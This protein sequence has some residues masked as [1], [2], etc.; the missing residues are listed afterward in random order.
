MNSQVLL[1][2]TS[3]SLIPVRLVHIVTY[4]R[5]LALLVN[6]C[7]D[8]KVTTICYNYQYY[9]NQLLIKQLLN[10][11]GLIPI[12]LN[13]H[14]AQVVNNFNNLSCWQPDGYWQPDG[15]WSARHPAVPPKALLP[16]PQRLSCSRCCWMVNH[17]WLRVCWCF[18][19]KFHG[20][21]SL[22]G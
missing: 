7:H 16:G 13:R 1:P 14:N 18:M 4:Y 2:N 22:S 12:I 15:R 17:W 3:V 20:W 11:G 19:V 8:L 10:S 9:S 6:H 21:W 5:Y